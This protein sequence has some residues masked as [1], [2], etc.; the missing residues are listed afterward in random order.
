[1]AK[2][3]DNGKSFEVDFKLG[4]PVAYEL[5][6]VHMANTSTIPLYGKILEPFSTDQ[7]AGAIETCYTTA[8]T[9]VSKKCSNDDAMIN[10]TFLSKEFYC[11]F[12]SSPEP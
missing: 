10:L 1:M 5:F 9:K 12:I 3:L 6:F 11:V 8:G 4:L 7:K 2:F